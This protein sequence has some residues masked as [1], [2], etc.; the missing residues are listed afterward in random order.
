VLAAIAAVTLL[1][2]LG[3]SKP[4]AFTLR[5]DINPTAPVAVATKAPSCT[6]LRVL[7]D[8]TRAV[9][10]QSMPGNAVPA[11]VTLKAADGLTA[12]T[13]GPKQ[14]GRN[15][16]YALPAP[17]KG[18]HL[19]ATACVN[20][21]ATGKT[22]VMG[23]DVR[24]S[25]ALLGDER[26]SWLSAIPLLASRAAY[27][28]GT[29]LGG[30]ALWLGILAALAAAGVLIRLAS[31]PM[32]RTEPV[33]RR[34][35]VLLGLVATLWGGAYAVTTPAFEAPDEMVHL[36]YA[37]LIHDQFQVPK[38]TKTPPNGLSPQLGTAIDASRVGGVAFNRAARPPWTGVEDRKLDAQLKA[39]PAGGSHDTFDNAS[40]QPPTYYAIVAAADTIAGGS[41]LDRLLIARL[42]SAL[43]FGL[44][45][46]GAVVFAREAVPRAGGL[47]VAGGAV[48]ACLPI[49]GFIGGSVNP[50]ALMVVTCAWSLAVTAMILR[51][52][53][54]WRR[55]LALGALIGLGIISKVTFAGLLP[56]FLV[57]ALV[58]LVRGV[59]A[60]ET[61][62]TVAQLA[63]AGALAV[64]VAGPY[65]GWAVLS[66][67][68]IAFGPPA[69]PF[70]PAGP[71]ETVVYAFELFIGQVG[72]IADR[73]PGSGPIDIWGAGLVGSLG[74][75]D[76]GFPLTA[77]LRIL[78]VW[79]ILAL[80]AVAGLVRSVR[81]RRTVPIDFVVYVVAAVGL[82]LLIAHSGLEARHQGASG[83]EQA[84][85]L[86]PVA[87]IGVGGVALA[88]RQVTTKYAA[89][90]WIAAAVVVAAL[91]HGVAGYLLTIG[92]YFA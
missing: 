26:G 19:T 49:V 27:A 57:A 15:L 5:A 62:T 79:G 69:A 7:P 78:D 23:S 13:T 48:L 47:V 39:L 46:A 9:R 44:G 34:T 21:A 81:A 52:G 41:I 66:G 20:A 8:D 2:L 36:R 38:T 90:D 91:S 12:T 18:D 45:I 50:D 56:A 70:L 87:A 28:R 60:G 17:I 6:D 73:I 4:P 75:V 74:W 11:S 40:S 80:L 42:V 54:T 25:V 14:D 16:V 32:R 58:V 65:V 83:F 33:G 1:L 88:L 59:R 84:R 55:A 86:F 68:G 10:L 82:A 53:V 29:V 35:I 61:K 3:L 24:P 89:R 22:A 64:A 77:A 85:Y 37:E 72:P 63:G 71:R 31:G 51:R 43:L 92:R 76:Y 67:R 30:A